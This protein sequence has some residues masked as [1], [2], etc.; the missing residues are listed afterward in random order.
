MFQVSNVLKL[1]ATLNSW[2]QYA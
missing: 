1:I 2:S